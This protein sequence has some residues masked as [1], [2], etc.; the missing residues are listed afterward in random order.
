MLWMDWDKGYVTLNHSQE[1]L[2]EFAAWLWSQTDQGLHSA[3][4]T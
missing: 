3:Y 4:V 2:M 1:Y